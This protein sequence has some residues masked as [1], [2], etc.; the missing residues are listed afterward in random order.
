VEVVHLFHSP[1]HALEG[2]AR[3]PDAVPFPVLADPD[4]SVYRAWGVTGGITSLLHPGAWRRALEATRA[5]LRPRWR[6][7]LRDGIG[8][9]P[10]DFLVGA[11]GTLEQAHY[12]AHFAD[13]VPLGEVLSWL[14]GDGTRGAL[15]KE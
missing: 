7:A 3:G 5:G 8:I 14:E 10:S 2:F 15:L 1:P 4:R 12:G 9:C 13:S 6:D 11:D